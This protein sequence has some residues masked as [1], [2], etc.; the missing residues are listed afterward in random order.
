MHD[1]IVV[2]LGAMGSAALYHLAS[3]GSR[4][5][6]VDTLDPPHSLGSTHGRSRIIREA[7]FEH[8]S[9]VPL[10]R[11]AYENW[12]ALERESGETLYRRTGG[13]MVGPPDC[14]LLRGTLDSVSMHGIAVETL[15][16]TEI[17]ERF[18]AF[19]PEPG[20]I[21]VYEQNAGMLFP[22]AC[23]R[24]YLRLASAKGAEV[25]AHTRVLSLARDH[26]V[27]SATTNAGIIK[28]KRVIVAA[29]AWT[30]DLIAPLGVDLPLTV[31]RQTMH[32]LEPMAESDLLGP[33]HFP[34]AI[35]EHAPGRMF[36]VMP[37]LGDGV[38][39]A[40]HYE[41]AFTAAESLNR[42][43]SE[44]DTVPVLELATRFVPAAAGAIRESAVCMYTNTPD[45]DFIVDTVQGMPE[46]LLVSACSGHGFKFASAIGEAVS[47]LALG[48]RVDA[49]LSHFRGDRW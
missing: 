35:F 9:Y 28:A 13:L 49:D 36:Y 10:V 27:I 34:V 32:W 25:R 12:A 3:R 38:K 43:I 7:Y 23:V 29:G 46:V 40:I 5:V 4:V 47:Q 44:S 17:V 26:G 31:E 42:E 21:G 8:P 30:R 48:E 2:G 18:P 1:V 15:S 6:G 22:E 11:R 19:H 37:N 20:M 45:L 14:A 24:V 33:D 39:A 41:G 16:A